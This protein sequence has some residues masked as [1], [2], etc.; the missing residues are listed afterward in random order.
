MDHPGRTHL[1]LGAGCP[2]GLIWM[3]LS[4]IQL[5]PLEAFLQNP[6]LD[7]YQQL[8]FHKVDRNDTSIAMQW[9][10]PDIPQSSSVTDS[11]DWP[12]PG[13]HARS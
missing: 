11:R 5:P 4:L 2:P 10:P 7:F 8:G 9:D 1:H 3:P 12:S 6:A 13:H